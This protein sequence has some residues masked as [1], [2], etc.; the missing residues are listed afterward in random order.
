[1]ALKDLW[2]F[3]P[4]QNQWQELRVRGSH[5]PPSLQEHTISF[6]NVS[7]SPASA[8]VPYLVIY[9]RMVSILYLTGK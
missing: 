8:S 5:M 2:L 4:M 3:D 9:F 6:W 7:T 1:M